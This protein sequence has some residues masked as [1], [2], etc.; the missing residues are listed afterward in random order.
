M[1]GNRRGDVL[2]WPVFPLP[3]QG[4][5]GAIDHDIDTDVIERRDRRIDP[6]QHPGVVDF[7]FRVIEN[8]GLAERRCG[9]D[10]E[11]AI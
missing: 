8:S 10:G 6:H 3:H 5:L 7:R 1:T 11:P 2:V 4:V 9:V